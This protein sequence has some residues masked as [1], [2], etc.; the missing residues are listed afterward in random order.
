MRRWAETPNFDRRLPTQRKPVPNEQWSIW[1]RVSVFFE[2][3]LVWRQAGADKLKGQQE[4]SLPCRPPACFTLVT[5]YYELLPT[6][7]N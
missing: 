6:S 7:N 4:E 1:Q 3:H 5:A 2:S